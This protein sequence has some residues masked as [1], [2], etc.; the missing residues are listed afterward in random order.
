FE[1]NTIVDITERQIFLRQTHL[2]DTKYQ[3]KGA[4]FGTINHKLFTDW[5]LDLSLSSS[6]FLELD[7]EDSEDTMY[8]GT[9]FIKGNAS[10]NGPTSGLT[11]SATATS[12]KGT[13][14]KIPIGSSK[15]VGEVSYI[16]FMS[17]NEKYNLNVDAPTGL[18]S[19]GLEMNFNLNVTPDA[20][21][22]E[23]HTSELQSRENL[24]CRLLLEKKK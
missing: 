7:T 15:S 3:T 13:H 11:I 5:I 8:Y 21:R 23:E 18:V 17:P 19:T 2:T 1:D 20:E 12:E 6:R 10:I 22:S 24:V 14:I 4:F 9:A 16:Q